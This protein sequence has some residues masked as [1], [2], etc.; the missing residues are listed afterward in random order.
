SF[1]GLLKTIFRLLG[2]PPLNLFD[3]AATDL[4]DCFTG[5]PDFT[6]YRLEKV[7]ERL[8]KP[9]EARLP[10]NPAPS[11]RLDDPRVLRE[12]HRR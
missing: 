10:L 5:T 3:A 12:Q 4:S 7:D 8:F 1:P 11:P 2:L 6:P 9:E